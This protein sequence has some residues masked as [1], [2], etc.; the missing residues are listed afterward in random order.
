MNLHA[1]EKLA[2]DL[3]AEFK[4]MDRFG[5]M[6]DADHQNWHFGF[7]NAKRRFGCCHSHRKLITLSRILVARNEQPEVEDCIRHEIAHALV[8]HKA[9]H[10]SEWKRMCARTGANPERCY[11]SEVVDAPEGNWQATCNGCGRSYTKFRRPNRDLWC[12]SKDCKRKNGGRL[13][14][15]Q[16]LV[17]RHKDA[18][19]V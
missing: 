8:G 12:S 3:M 5:H 2:L 6:Y 14:P 16:H 17:W 19:T 4:L 9:G 15:I 7:D 13:L 18:L 1:A 11:D 10:G